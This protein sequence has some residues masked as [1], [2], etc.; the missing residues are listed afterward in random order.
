M[1]HFNLH[2]KTFYSVANSSNGEVGA[3]TVFR[4]FQEEDLVWASYSGGSIRYGN[5][6]GKWLEDDQLE[7]RYQHLS[8][9]GVLKTGR[10]HSTP[11]QLPD[12]RLRLYEEWQWTSG[13]LLSGTSV[14]EEIEQY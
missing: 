8:E 12:G 6:V 11:E 4:Y 1:P 14:I 3:A 7:I 9:D 13:D 2:Q 5:I 10:C